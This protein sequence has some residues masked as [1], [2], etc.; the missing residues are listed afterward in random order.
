VTA[1]FNHFG[2]ASV[3]RGKVGAIFACAGVCLLLLLSAA[4]RES[5]SKETEAASH[6]SKPVP[7]ETA[8]VVSRQIPKTLDVTGTLAADETSNVAAAGGGQVRATPAAPGSYVREGDVLVEMD[9]GDAR[10]RVTQAQSAVEQASV[11]LRQAEISI[12]MGTDGKFDPA[13]QPEVIGAKAAADTADNQ[14]KLAKQ[15]LARY[16]NLMQTG[17]ISNGAFEQAYQQSMAAGEQAKSAQ[18]GYLS[19]LNRAK[20]AYQ[21]LDALR[22]AKAAGEAQLALAQRAMESMTIRA[23]FAGVLAARL[24]SPGEVL[25][26]GGRVATLLRTNPLQ[27]QAQVPEAD[28]A[29]LRNGL[30]VTIRVAAF[31]DRQFGGVVQTVGAAVDPASRTV[32]VQARIDNGEGLLRPGMFASGRVALAAE[33]AALFVPQAAVIDT[34]GRTATVV[35]TIDGN[36]AHAALVRKGEA[37]GG[38]V[39]IFSGLAANQVVATEG[40]QNLYDGAAVIARH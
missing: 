40:A 14:A 39:H 21:G 2:S 16:T 15:N 3:D 35:Y 9:A 38:L 29:A 26:P 13:A 37:A 28:S 31:G 4:C 10:L 22:A 11:A 30:R 23:P 32:T 12:A 36:T 5:Q 7:V 34:S 17:D 33:E 20:G 6:A 19:A 18:Q 8:G 27:L 25:P 24:V 1:E